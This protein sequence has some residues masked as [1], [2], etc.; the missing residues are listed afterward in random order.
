MLLVD[1]IVRLLPGVI[2]D[3]DSAMKDSFMDDLLEPA[4]YTRPA[5][6]R[7]MKVPEYLMGGNHAEIEKRRLDESLHKT[8]RLRPDLYKKFM[9]GE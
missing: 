5:E 4:Q 6:Y 7:G 2:S 1:S 8:K 3:I 9:D